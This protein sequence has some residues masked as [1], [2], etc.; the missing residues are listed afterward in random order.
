MVAMTRRVMDERARRYYGSIRRLEKYASVLI[1]AHSAILPRLSPYLRSTRAPKR[2]TRH[3]A[4]SHR[5]GL[6]PA[7]S[8]STPSR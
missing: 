7:E 1:R 4:R 2:G 6:T 5:R 3:A 8:S